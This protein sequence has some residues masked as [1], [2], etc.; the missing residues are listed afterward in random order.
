M[1]SKKKITVFIQEMKGNAW[2][3]GKNYYDNL[4]KIVTSYFPEISFCT[5][6]FFKPELVAAQTIES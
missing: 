3:G 2:L 1:S 6:D 5:F 4:E